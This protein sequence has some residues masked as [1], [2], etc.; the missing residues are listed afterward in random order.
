MEGGEDSRRGW[1]HDTIPSIAIRIKG[2]VAWDVFY[3]FFQYFIF[4][5]ITNMKNIYFGKI[6]RSKHRFRAFKV[7]RGHTKN[8]LGV[9]SEYEYLLYFYL[10]YEKMS[11]NVG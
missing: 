6:D 4:L 8:N 2:S 1:Y 11:V 5:G 9:P 7:L 10:K 3:C